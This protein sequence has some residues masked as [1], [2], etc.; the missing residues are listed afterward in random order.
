MIIHICIGWFF[1]ELH[2]AWHCRVQILEQSIYCL[3]GSYSACIR[4]HEQI[5]G[6][7]YRISVH[8]DTLIYV[9]LQTSNSKLDLISLRSLSIN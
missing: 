7:D 2:S 8:N 1:K 5:S 3:H 9:I 4:R 6:L